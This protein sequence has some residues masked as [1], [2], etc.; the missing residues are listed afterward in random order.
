MIASG[1][2][3]VVEA[4][5][6]AIGL[7]QLMAFPLCRLLRTPQLIL[8]ALGWKCNR[9]GGDVS[10]RVIVPMSTCVCLCRSLQHRARGQLWVGGAGSVRLAGRPLRVGVGAMIALRLQLRCP[11][12][13]LDAPRALTLATLGRAART[14]PQTRL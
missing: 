9:A 4:V 8:L 5:L 2:I 7:K 10:A 13:P 14:M 12:A 6:H 11:D 3:V 1:A